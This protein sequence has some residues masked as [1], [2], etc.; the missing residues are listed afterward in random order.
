MIQ[1]SL[2]RD[3]R[4]GERER[5]QTHQPEKSS[6]R[7]NEIAKLEKKENDNNS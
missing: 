3:E 4:K 5:E 6:L 2:T 1:N 7:E